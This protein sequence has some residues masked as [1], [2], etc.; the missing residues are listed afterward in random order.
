MYQGRDIADLPVVLES[1]DAGGVVITF[2]DR[3][4]AVAGTVSGARGADATAVVIAYPTD[5]SL[6][7]AT[8]RRMRTARVAADGSFAIQALPSGEYYVVAVQEDLVGEWQDPALL[9]ALS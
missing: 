6:W 3:P 2:T 1:K 9:Q 4:S 8:P 5:P 7:T